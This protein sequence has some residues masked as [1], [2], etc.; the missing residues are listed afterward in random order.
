MACKYEKEIREKVQKETSKK[1]FEF[2]KFITIIGILF[3]LYVIL[4][5]SYATIITKDLSAVPE[6]V[7]GTSGLMATIAGFYY[8]KAKAENKIKL[9][10]S[11]GIKPDKDTFENI[12]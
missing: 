11:Y 10:K 9:M 3:F 5:A 6:M 7:I 2:S 8:S 12:E 4:F 1:K